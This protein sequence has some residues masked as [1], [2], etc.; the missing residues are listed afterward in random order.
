MSD[1]KFD[2]LSEELKEKLR[3]CKSSDELQKVLMEEN[4][5]LDPD[6]LEAVSGG[7]EGELIY[8]SN[9]DKQKIPLYKSGPLADS[10]EPE[11][12]PDLRPDRRPW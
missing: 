3:N 9:K 1:Q 6:T 2:K 7:L 10:D 5:E 4:I 8:C 12:R 11:S